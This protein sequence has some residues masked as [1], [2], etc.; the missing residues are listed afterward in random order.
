MAPRGDRARARA[1]AREQ[2]SEGRAA[3]GLRAGRPRRARGRARAARGRRR[4]RRRSF[5][6]AAR[7]VAARRPGPD[8]AAPQEA[9]W[10][11][12]LKS[13]RHR[14]S[15]RPTRGLPRGRAV[16]V[17]K[18]R[19]RIKL[20]RPG[21]QLRLTGVF[22]G[23]LAL[24]L[25]LQAFVFVRELMSIAALLPSDG[26]LVVNELQRTVLSVLGISLAVLLPI[27]A[28]IGVHVTHRIAGPVHR[29]EG[30]LRAVARGER[31]RDCSLRKGDELNELCQ[32]VNDATQPL[33][34]AQAP[35]APA[36]QDARGGERAAA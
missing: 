27:T 9:G 13:G 18:Y 36:A 19:R 6:G 34:G 2:R 24:G 20:I 16:P 29:I 1:A 10:R 12:R 14:R 35:A 8:G 26:A 25:L 5:R 21:L 15:M 4:R 30:F 31:P 28:W 22:V 3:G 11:A 33:R 32:A 17:P 7:R 23:L